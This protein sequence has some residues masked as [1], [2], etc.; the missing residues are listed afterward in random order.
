[1]LNHQ[2]KESRRFLLRACDDD[3]PNLWL[4]KMSDDSKKKRQKHISR[5]GRGRRGILHGDDISY[6]SQVLS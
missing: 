3:G 4:C 6:R 2:D 5:G 1:M